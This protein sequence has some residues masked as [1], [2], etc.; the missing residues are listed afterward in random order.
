VGIYSGLLAFGYKQEEHTADEEV[1]SRGIL[2][3]SGIWRA[4][5]SSGVVREPATFSRMS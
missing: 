4:L 5:L 2:L 3:R 1:V